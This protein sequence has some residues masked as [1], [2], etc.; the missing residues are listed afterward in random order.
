MGTHVSKA[1]ETAN[2]GY[3]GQDASHLM[4]SKG[5]VGPGKIFVGPIWALGKADEIGAGR[6]ITLINGPMMADIVTPPR[7]GPAGH[8][9]LVMNDI[10]HPAEGLIAPDSGHVHQLL[11]FLEDWDQESPLLIHCHAGIS[12]SPAAAFIALCLLRPQIAEHELAQQLRAASAA[13]KPNRLLV[14]LADEILSREGRMIAACAALTVPPP[15]REGP[16]CSIGL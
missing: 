3:M 12:R 9:R 16:F 13:A 10:D 14:R 2:R 7:I 6:A 15:S 1:A 5:V 11:D 8:L 4:E